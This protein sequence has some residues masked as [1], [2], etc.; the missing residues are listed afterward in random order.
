MDRPIV[1]LELPRGYG[2]AVLWL[3]VTGDGAGQGKACPRLSRVRKGIVFVQQ[4]MP[5][6]HQLRQLAG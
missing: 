1:P 2:A 6:L 4:R 5:I 3:Y